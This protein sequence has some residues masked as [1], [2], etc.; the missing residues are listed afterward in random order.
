MQSRTL[1]LQFCVNFYASLNI[2]SEPE[3]V[4]WL[5]SSTTVFALGL[6][7]RS[8]IQV[9]RLRNICCVFEHGAVSSDA[10][11]PLLFYCCLSNTRSRSRIQAMRLHNIIFCYI[12]CLMCVLFYYFLYLLFAHLKIHNVYFLST[13]VCPGAFFILLTF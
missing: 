13:F 1:R 8:R 3:Q 9:V 12:F 5:Q 4:L 11:P 2:I 10:A 6:R 7:S